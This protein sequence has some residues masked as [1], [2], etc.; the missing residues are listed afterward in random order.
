MNSF[1]S[2]YE[3]IKNLSLLDQGE[4][5]YAN[6]NSWNSNPEHAEFYYIPWDY[7]QNLDDDEIYHDEEDMEMPLVVKGLNLRG[8][9]LVGSLDYIIQNKS[10]FEHD[11]KWLID[12]INYYRN[13]DTFRT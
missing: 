3:L 10:D 6:L 13:N 4:W 9:M 7:I 5:I 11:N 2:I 12:E 1:K 8:W